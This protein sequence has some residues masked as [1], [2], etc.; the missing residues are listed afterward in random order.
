[1]D[2]WGK[3]RHFSILSESEFAPFSK[4][5]RTHRYYTRRRHHKQSERERNIIR[6]ARRI[7][8]SLWWQSSDSCGH[9]RRTEAED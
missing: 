8:T 1:M 7:K 4:L 6:C 2:V 9:R 5:F 3:I